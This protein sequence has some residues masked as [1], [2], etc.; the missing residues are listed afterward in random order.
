MSLP[1]ALAAA[2]KGDNAATLAQLVSA[3][4]K[5][6]ALAL[7][8]A[9]AEVAR[10]ADAEEPPLEGTKAGEREEAWQKRAAKERPASLGVLLASLLD[11]KGSAQTQGRLVALTPW[12][13]DPR[14]AAVLADILEKPPYNGSVS[15][16]TPFWKFVFAA[17]PKLGDPRLLERA[18]KLPDAWKVLPSDY[19][20]DA[21]NGRLKKIMPELEKAYGKGVPS[22]SADDAKLLAEVVAAA[23]KSGGG[24]AATK[25]GNRK[26]VEQAL[27]EVYERPADDAPRLVLADLLQEQGDPRGEFITL[28]FL[29][30]DGK[31]ST[32]Q[33]RKEKALF[34]KHQKEWLGA[35]APLVLKSELV[36][37]RGFVA[38][39]RIKTLSTDPEW[40]TVSHVEGAIPDLEG[41]PV[42][43]IT[44]AQG[45]VRK[46]LRH[47][48]NLKELAIEDIW[49]QVNYRGPDKATPVITNRE[50]VKDYTSLPLKLERVSLLNRSNT[51]S[52]PHVLPS[53]FKWL[54]EGPGQ[55]LKHLAL[56]APFEQ[57][58]AW[59]EEAAKRGLRTLRLSCS[60]SDQGA[61]QLVIDVPAN[62]LS[63][64]GTPKV[65][66]RWGAEN[67]KVEFGSAAMLIQALS[68]AKKFAKVDIVD[69]KPTPKEQA[70][71]G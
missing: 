45:P 60:G 34:E 3:W 71:L 51:W 48:T 16:T 37:E 68:A 6:P 66:Q 26:N 9:I 30:R 32:A 63:V 17:L 53:T 64:E 13:Q 43:G 8:D 47:L 44:S 31:S 5:T 52:D 69:W 62:T 2:Q 18:K 59:R 4:K 22:L 58:D 56:T 49:L 28:Q 61:F 46:G 15:R 67:E 41:M 50:L 65:L 54:F 38:R 10:L 1:K 12:C 25:E 24:A 35:I 55:T 70:A 19:E 33:L 36:F 23:K 14:L 39:C 21:L 27:R 29:R 20:R 11:T 7:N 42:A 40:A 57:L